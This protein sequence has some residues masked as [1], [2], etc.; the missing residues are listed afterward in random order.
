MVYNTFPLPGL[1]SDQ[2][3]SLE[4][5]AFEILRSRENY[6]GKTIEWLYDPDTMP[7]ELLGA[8]RKLDDTLERLYI[9]RPFKNDTEQLEHMF[10]LYAAMIKKEE[11]LAAQK[12]GAA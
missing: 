6:P 7:S 8:H 2:K 9:G 3:Q 10:K 11:A 5:H 4:L 1:S 12:K